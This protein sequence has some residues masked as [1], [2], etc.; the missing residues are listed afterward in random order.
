MSL[1]MCAIT[2]GKCGPTEYYCLTYVLV[3]TF[4]MNR[5]CIWPYLYFHL[6]NENR[7]FDHLR[8]QA[9]SYITTLL[10]ETWVPSSRR[11]MGGEVGVAIPLCRR[12]EYRAERRCHF[13][14]APVAVCRSRWHLSRLLCLPL[15]LWRSRIIWASLLAK[16]MCQRQLAHYPSHHCIEMSRLGNFY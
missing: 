10:Y 1:R 16:S 2:K 11:R 14:I 15:S 9:T 7:Q 4:F 12:I 13:I 5:Q 3:V 8:V 6:S